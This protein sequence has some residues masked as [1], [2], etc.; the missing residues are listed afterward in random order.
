MT[1]REGGL[2]TWIR[3]IRPEQWLKNGFVLSPLVFSGKALLWDAQWRALVAFAAFCAVAS[4]VYLMNDVIDRSADRLHPRKATRP[5]AAGLI[6]TRSA[7]AVSAA[8][9]VIGLAAGAVAGLQVAGVLLAYLALNVLYGTWLKNVVIVDVFVIA[10]FF[11]M[12]LV[13]GAV[14]VDVKPSIWLLLCG[15]LLAL[16]LGFAKRR[17]ELVLLGGG[18]P[19]HRAVLADY[20]TTFLDQLSVVLLSVTI[21]SYIMYTLESDTARIVGS[22]SLS[23][24]TAF[25]LYGVLR[26][27]YLV[28]R[29]EGGNPTETLLTDR[30]LLAAVVLWGAYCGAIIYFARS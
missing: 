11:V 19:T 12:R 21:V 10:A 14:A 22:E 18:S 3:A 8:L 1:D 4:A 6:S 5:I 29:N 20:S 28:H 23:Y 13:A 30:S 25:V 27:L 24:S 7:L 2:R 26:Y 16:Y 15:G 9:G 17:H